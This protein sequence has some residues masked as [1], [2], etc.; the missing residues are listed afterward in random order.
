MEEELEEVEEEI[1]QLASVV[2]SHLSHTNTC[3]RVVVS[4]LLAYSYTV[5]AWRKPLTPDPIL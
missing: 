3:H 4:S 1:S 5:C 2:S